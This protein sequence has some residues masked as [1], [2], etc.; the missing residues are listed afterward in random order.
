MSGGGLGQAGGFVTVVSGLPRSGTSM[1]MQMLAAGGM[2][3]L[4]D[5]VRAAD[6]DNPLGYFEYEPVKRSA[7]DVAWVAGSVGKA[8]KV[9]HLLLPC[10]PAEYQYRVLFIRR[11]MG[12]VLASQRRMLERSGRRGAELAESRLAEIFEGQVGRVLEWLGRQG[13]FSLLPLEYREVTAN[14]LAAARRMNRFLNGGMDE[15]AMA[16]RVIIRPAEVRSKR[17]REREP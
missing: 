8:V 6:E 15:A 2:P 17:Q 1:L 16:Q 4:T 12:D 11:E 9:V 5:G 14:P 10:L 3:V 13:N 7:N